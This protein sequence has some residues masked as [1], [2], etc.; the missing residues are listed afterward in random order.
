MT[1]LDGDVFYPDPAIAAGSRVPDAD[2]FRAQALADPQQFWADEASELEWFQPWTQVLDDSE[3]PFFKWFVGGRT[4][5]VH[6]CLDRHVKGPNKNKL[7]LIWMSEDGNDH[8]TFSYF[9]LNR[10][11]TMMA[12]VIRSMG[13]GKGDKV[14]IYLPRIP[15]VVFA[16]LACAKI[17]AVHSV[18][19]AGFSS[20]ALTSRID[21]SESKLVITSD[22]SWVNGSVFPLKDIVDEAVRF[23][24]RSRT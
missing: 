14:T 23:S 7:A 13:V 8:R 15:E 11:V 12:N 21:D 3:A 9:S 6:N 22:G 4:N 20:D 19:F 5:I 16:M 18:V 17:G 10:Q 1:Q 24:P 2:A